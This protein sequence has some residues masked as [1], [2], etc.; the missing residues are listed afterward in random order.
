MANTSTQSRR[1]DTANRADVPPRRLRDL[2]LG[3]FV[4]ATA[5]L[6]VGACTA[7]S[8]G[9]EAADQETLQSIDLT[10]V[11]FDDDETIPTRFT[12]EGENVPPPISWEGVPEGAVELVLSMEDPDAPSGTFRHWAVSGID[13]ST[14]ALDPATVPDGAVLGENDFGEVGYGGPCPPDGDEPHRYVFTVHA[15]DRASGLETGFSASE[16]REALE[17]AEIARGE[18]IGVFGR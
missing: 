6:V 2:L 18:L 8:G 13:P 16:M 10:S 14:S 4:T 5:A 11:S 3:V 1:T 9:T 17:G 15:I 12:C 7:D